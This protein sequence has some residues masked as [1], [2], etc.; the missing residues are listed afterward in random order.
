VSGACKG[1]VEDDGVANAR[2]LP[3]PTVAF[4]LSIY[5]YNLLTNSTPPAAHNLIN[6]PAI[7]ESGGTL[8]NPIFSP[9]PTSPLPSEGAKAASDSLSV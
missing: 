8:V 7:A 4:M 9:C 2:L 1:T 5:D 3:L 6:W